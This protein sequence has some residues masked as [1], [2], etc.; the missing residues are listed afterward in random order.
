[1]VYVDYGAAHPRAISLEVVSIG[2]PPVPDPIAE[3]NAWAAAAADPLWVADRD[4]M[5][6]EAA[7]VD[8]EVFD[9]LPFEA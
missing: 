3:A 6:A 4:A 8:A 5:L 2:A 9:H 7:P 1:M